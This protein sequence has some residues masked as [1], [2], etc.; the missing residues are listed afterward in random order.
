MG[1][2]TDSNGMINCSSLRQGFS[3][4]QGDPV[5]EDDSKISTLHE[6]LESADDML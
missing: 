1:A 5:D 2:G 4:K 3:Y 6:D